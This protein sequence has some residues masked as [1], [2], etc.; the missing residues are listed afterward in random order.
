MRWLSA[1]FEQSPQSTADHFFDNGV[2]PRSVKPASYSTRHSSYFSRR[3]PLL[4]LTYLVVFGIGTL[5]RG[6]AIAAVYSRL[7]PFRLLQ[8]V[9]RW[10][11]RPPPPARWLRTSG[12]REHQ[13]LQTAHPDEENS[14]CPSS[15]PAFHVGSVRPDRILMR[16]R[17][18]AVICRNLVP[19]IRWKSAVANSF[20]TS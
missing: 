2:L 3:V 6:Y 8:L 20:S 14:P 13:G 7:F 10:S 5:S 9:S 1:R 17:P 12:T 11:L 18:D 16:I 19:D 15:W 4:V